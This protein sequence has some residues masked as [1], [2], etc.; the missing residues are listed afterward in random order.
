[1]RR[2]EL[3]LREMESAPAAA[4]VAERRRAE[5]REREFVDKANRFARLWT[6]FATEYNQR[7]TFN[8]KTAR[9]LSKAFRELEQEGW[10]KPVAK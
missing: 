8:V 4:E 2:R 6:Q 7:K 10:P 9:E 3:L 1:M 5:S